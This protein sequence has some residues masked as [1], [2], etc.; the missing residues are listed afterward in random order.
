[1]FIS[2]FACNNTK[3]KTSE[4]KPTTVQAEFLNANQDVVFVITAEKTDTIILNETAKFT[5]NADLEKAEYVKMHDTRNSFELY[6]NPGDSINLT[7]DTGKIENALVFNN[8]NPESEYLMKMNDIQKSNNELLYIQSIDTFLTESG[9]T[10]KEMEDLL[11]S[12]D[13]KIKDK[14]F[15]E[16]EQKRINYIFYN[17]KFTY[18]DY[19]LYF[20]KDEK[21]LEDANY[22]DFVNDLDMEDEASLVFESYIA[23]LD[24]KITYKTSKQDIKNY[25]ENV[26]ANIKEIKA[27]I[28]NEKI[29]ETLIFE[30]IMDYGRYDGFAKIENE[31]QDFI[32]TAKNEK[33]LAKAKE[34]HEI[35]DNLSA[36]KPAPKFEYPNQK[37][38][39]VSLESF[40]GKYVYIDVWATWCGPCRAE[41]PAFKKLEAEYHGKNIAFLSV[42]VDDNKDAWLKFI[43]DKKLEWPQLHTG[44]WLCSITEDYYI[45]SIP[46]F[47]LIDTEGKIINAS[48]ARPS[49]E[50][51]RP[52]LNELLK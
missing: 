12:Y 17:L 39:M 1:M 29:K 3:D 43:N 5:W 4:L 18:K 47:I 48:A 35:W 8:G 15:M 32:A 22:F 37:E 6:L 40:L 9:K 19:F 52:L 25:E 34:V 2:M 23:S 16:M 41:V 24:K 49:S 46:R 7:F 20:V 26:I 31:Y 33:N 51:I 14:H 36:G 50:E 38:E 30:T 45:N 28:Q 10:Q 44:G 13:K 27:S 11:A 42:S 21:A